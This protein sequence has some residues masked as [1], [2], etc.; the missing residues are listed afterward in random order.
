MKILTVKKTLIIFYFLFSYFASAQDSIKT[1]DQL[2]ELVLTERNGK[3]Q[4]DAEKPATFPL[5][6]TALRTMIHENFRM[7]KIIT[8]ADQEFCEL[9]FVIDREGSM[10]EVKTLGTNISF[11]KEAERALSKIKQRWIPAEMNGQK[12]RYRFRIPLTLTFDKK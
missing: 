8:N 2:S 7:R 6:I 10:V 5:G 12:V 3:V 4:M 1:Y 11:N 9:I